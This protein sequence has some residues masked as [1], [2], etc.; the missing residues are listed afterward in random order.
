MHT[1]KKPFD[2]KSNQYNILNK[3]VYITAMSVLAH[4]FDAP[5]NLHLC[6]HFLQPGEEP[7]SRLT[8]SSVHPSQ[9]SATPLWSSLGSPRPSGS[10]PA[11][12]KGSHSYPH[13][14]GRESPA[15]KTQKGAGFDSSVYLE[16]N[17]QLQTV[18]A[19][20]I[21]WEPLLNLHSPCGLQ[22]WGIVCERGPE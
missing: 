2:K 12:S 17:P 13:P 11:G 19:G 7:K 21:N 3:T 10:L 4:N 14:F 5:L 15:D 8:C 16:L 20:S 1:Q 22:E 18:A 6:L 9:S